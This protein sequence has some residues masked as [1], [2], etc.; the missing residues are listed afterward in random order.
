MGL[1]CRAVGGTAQDSVCCLHTWGTQCD[2]TGQGLWSPSTLFG[3]Q[4]AGRGPSGTVTGGQ[5]TTKPPDT[6][7]GADPQAGG[8]VLHRFALFVPFW[9][10]SPFPCMSAAIE[11]FFKQRNSAFW[12]L[13]IIFGSCSEKVHFFFF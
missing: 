3:L 5:S 1:S 7:L 12:L 6:H 10:C 11:C 13:Q 2:G 8:V 9:F 4:A